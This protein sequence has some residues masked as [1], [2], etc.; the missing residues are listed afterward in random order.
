MKKPISPQTTAW[1]FRSDRRKTLVPRR[2]FTSASPAFWQ[3]FIR[4]NQSGAGPNEH[5]GN[6]E[7]L[8]GGVRQAFIQNRE[9]PT[10]LNDAERAEYVSRLL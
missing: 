9:I 1:E 4:Q 8:N 3:R 6:T 2:R 10:D 7:D 5:F